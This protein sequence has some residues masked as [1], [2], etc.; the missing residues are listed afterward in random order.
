GRA[1]GG[2]RALGEWQG[3]PPGRLRAPQGLPPVRRISLVHQVDARGPRTLSPGSKFRAA[4]ARPSQALGVPMPY[5]LTL[6][7]NHLA[8]VAVCPPIL[9]KCNLL[10]VHQHGQDDRRRVRV[11]VTRAPGTLKPKDAKES[12]EAR[13][14]SITTPELKKK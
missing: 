8:R 13:I 6:E 12:K 11:Q 7:E 9:A 14:G 4:P 1:F 5:G 2:F 3:P 10:G